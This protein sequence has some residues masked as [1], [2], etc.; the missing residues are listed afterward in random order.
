MRTIA[1]NLASVPFRRD[2]PLLAA[3]FALGLVMVALFAMQVYLIWLEK[4]VGK[5]TAAEI[6]QVREQLS[7]L[8]GEQG[9]LE[10]FLR[11]PENE[12]VLETSI[13]LNHLL[14]RK[15]VSWTMVFQDL[16]QVLP[17]NVKLMSVR[18]QVFGGDEEAQPTEILLELV[19]ASDALEPVIDMLKALE[20][21]RL[22]GATALSS[23]LPPTETEPL[24]RCR[25]SVKYAREL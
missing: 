14:K 6:A 10:G 11:R 1:V 23:S 9:R 17:H 4:D 20:S 22:F 18:P 15:G 12:A 25:V 21:S 2:R 13:F 5:E 7:K 8:T 24:Y 16:E 19:V 3:A